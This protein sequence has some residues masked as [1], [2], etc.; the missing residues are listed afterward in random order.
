LSNVLDG[1]EYILYSIL[2]P[3]SIRAAQ[4]FHY[5]VFSRL[6]PRHELSTIV[7][8]S[9]EQR[10]I[11]IQTKGVAMDML[12]LFAIVMLGLLVARLVVYKKSA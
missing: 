5:Q 9:S 7:A 6:V 1:P 4:A 2:V 8:H 3:P 11:I 10:G 12:T